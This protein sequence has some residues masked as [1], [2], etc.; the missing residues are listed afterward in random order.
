MQGSF[1]AAGFR[2][3][4][5][6]G[7]YSGFLGYTGAA[8]YVVIGAAFALAA[9][10]W[11][12]SS[13][14]ERPAVPAHETL[15]AAV[16][17]LTPMSAYLLAVVVTGALTSKYTIALVAGIAILVGYLL[18]CGEARH[19]GLVAA[20]TVLLAIWAVGRHVSTVLDYRGS[21][22]VPAAISDALAR[23]SEPVAFDSPHL[24]LQFVHYQPQRAGRFVYPMDAATALEVRGFNNDEIALR[25]LQQIR[26]LNVVGYREFVGRHDTFMVVYSRVFWP[27]LVKALRRDGYC[28]AKVAESGS[29]ELLQAFPGCRPVPR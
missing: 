29:T 10:G 22:A 20:T 21:A 17:A 26:A 16:L 27:A 7:Y 8:A 18:A 9:L 3:A 23:S 25:G 5:L 11:R 14:A 19:R 2:F 13:P 15:A 12:R 24:F 28:L 6:P 4:E 1:W